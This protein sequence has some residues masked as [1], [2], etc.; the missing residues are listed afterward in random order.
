MKL[1]HA[2]LLC[3]TLVLTVG[4]ATATGGNGTQTFQFKATYDDS[5]TPGVIWNCSGVRQVKKGGALV[6]SETCQVTGVPANTFV[7]GTYKPTG[8]GFVDPPGVLCAINVP[9]IPGEQAPPNGFI[10]TTW[11]TWASD[12]DA[13]TTGTFRCAQNFALK[14]TD[15]GGGVWK[16]TIDATY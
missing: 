8:V 15:Q 2:L 13:F 5:F 12:Y 9:G 10:G 11:S 6:D 4:V 14:F 1:R 3:A 7:A 16:V